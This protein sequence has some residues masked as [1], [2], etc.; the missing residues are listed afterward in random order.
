MYRDLSHPL[1]TTTAYPGDPS[2]EIEP[3]ATHE[4]D[5]YRVSRLRLGTHSGTH[6][7]APR[8]IEPDGR[9]LDSFPI[10]TFSFDALLVDCRGKGA[11]DA[12]ER[13]ALPE[14]TEDDMLVFDTGWDAR[15]GTDAYFDHPYL[16]SDAAAW[17]ADHDYH[18]AVDAPSVDP[19]PTENA[20]G[21]EPEGLP[22]HRELL[23]ADRL[24]V[25]NLTGLAGL[26]ERFALYAF[27][28]S[29]GGVDGAPVRAV[30]E[31]RD[32][33]DATESPD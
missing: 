1:E 31:F 3:H 27:P 28:L 13:D 14:P 10:G 9:P 11:R 7:D 16:A 33:D 12:I 22:A 17:C 29:V 26:P 4:T 24:I 15:W 23:G 21:D 8:H 18:V 30:A 19:T 2:V 6:V 5:G 20:G 25:E 32:G